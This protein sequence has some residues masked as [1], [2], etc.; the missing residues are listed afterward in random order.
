MHT[1][2][3]SVEP[4]TVSQ[5]ASSKPHALPWHQKLPPL[6]STRFGAKFLR[7]VVILIVIF[8]IWTIVEV[9]RGEPGEGFS[10][11]SYFLCCLSLLLG[12]GFLLWIL[13]EGFRK[14]AGRPYEKQTSEPSDP[15]VDS[16][17][18]SHIEG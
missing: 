16:S 8:T 14:L 18:D 1:D 3:Q 5:A 6:I 12:G 13:V 7:R 2:L 10:T 15:I 9:V 11:F 4:T 17:D